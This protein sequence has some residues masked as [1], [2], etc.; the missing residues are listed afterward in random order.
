MNNIHFHSGTSFAKNR[1]GYIDWLAILDDNCPF[2]LLGIVAFL[3][4][5]VLPGLKVDGMP[6]I[7]PLF[8]DF[9]H[10]R[11]TPDI[12]VLEGLVL[13]HALS[14]LGKGAEE[15]RTCSSDSFLAIWYGHSLSMVI[16]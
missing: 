3:V 4:L 1:I 8:Q 11:E 10:R 15:I 6:Q 7:L 14:M 9:H 13:V 16:W 12:N 5:K 2:V